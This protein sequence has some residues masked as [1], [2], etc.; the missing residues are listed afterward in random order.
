MATERAGMILSDIFFESEVIKFKKE[1]YLKGR[2][3]GFYLGVKQTIKCIHEKGG[4]PA[5]QIAAITGFQVE[6]VQENI[7]KQNINTPSVF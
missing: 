1:A 7:D 4:L 6:F 3:E 5:E 2:L